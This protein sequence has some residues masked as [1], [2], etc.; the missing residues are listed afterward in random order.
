MALF[1]RGSKCKFCGS[2][3]NRRSEVLI[4]PHMTNNTSE[5]LA[6]FNSSAFHTKCVLAHP[7]G[8]TAIRQ[9]QYI[10][11]SLSPATPRWC[12]L[13]NGRIIGHDKQV[14]TGILTLDEKQPLFR[15]NWLTAHKKCL[16]HWHELPDLISELENYLEEG[17]WKDYHPEYRVLES[18]ASTLKVYVPGRAETA[19]L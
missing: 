10:N 14:G 7:W 15:F 12:A 16:T 6:A 11:D 2:A 13:C 3:M 17:Q 4:F 18:L 19:M 8:K 1:V 9:K 5:P